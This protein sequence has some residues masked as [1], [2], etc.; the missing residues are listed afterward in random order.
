MPSGLGALPMPSSEL[1]VLSSV[2]RVIM[3]VR[4]R[5]GSPRG[6]M[7][8]GSGFSGCSHGGLGSSSGVARVSSLSKCEWTAAITLWGEAI[9]VVSGRVTLWRVEVALLWGRR[10]IYFLTRRWQDFGLAS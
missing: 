2:S 3:S 7:T 1:S 4:V 9:S 10:P 8:N 5:E 6:S